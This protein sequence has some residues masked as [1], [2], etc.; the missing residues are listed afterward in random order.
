MAIG[1][2]IEKFFLHFST[3][4]DPLIPNLPT[5]KKKYYYFHV[6]NNSSIERKVWQSV[7][8]SKIFFF[9]FLHVSRPPDSEPPHPKKKVLLLS[10]SEQ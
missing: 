3:F 10:L 9:A 7:Q 1:P 2:K 4:H 6:Q 8:K 5:P